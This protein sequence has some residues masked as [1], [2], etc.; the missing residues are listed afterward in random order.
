[1]TEEKPTGDSPPE[2]LQ[3]KLDLVE[4]ALAVGARYKEYTEEYLERLIQMDRDFGCGRECHKCKENYCI[5]GQRI[6]D[7]QEDLKR[8]QSPNW[9]FLDTHDYTM[10]CKRCGKRDPMPQ[11]P[12]EVGGFIFLMS[13]NASKHWECK[14]VEIVEPTVA[15]GGRGPGA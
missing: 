8:S 7:V 5:I 4:R 13:V 15:E 12:M 10:R 6:L 2:T 11:L 1:M 9:V 14:E 3:P